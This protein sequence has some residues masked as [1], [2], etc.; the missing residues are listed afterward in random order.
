MTSKNATPSQGGRVSGRC[1][2]ARVDG[3]RVGVG[4]AGRGDECIGRCADQR[5][6]ALRQLCLRSRVS[7]KQKNSFGKGILLFTPY[8]HAP[9]RNPAPNLISFDCRGC[10]EP[11]CAWQESNLHRKLRKLMSPAC[12]RQCPHEESNLNSKIRNLV[13]Y[14]LND[15]GVLVSK[16]L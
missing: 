10:V 11:L 13:S 6:M 15:R 16:T 5:K 7:I 2:L 9:A 8:F 12:H 14:P 1:E 4:G 3:R